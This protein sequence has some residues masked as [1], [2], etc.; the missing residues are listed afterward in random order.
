MDYLYNPHPSTRHTVFAK[1][2]MVATS[3]PLAA[4]AGIEIMRRGGNAIDAAIATAAALTVVEPTSNGIGGDAF[5][6]IW[7]NNKLHGLNAS[8]PAPQALTIDAVKAQGHDK[9]PVHGLTPITVPGVPA[10]WAELARKFGKLPLKESLEP[11]IRYAEEGYPLTPILGKYWSAAYKKYRTSFTT[12]EFDAWFT[13]FAPDGRAP[14]IGELW[15]SPDHAATLKSIGASNAESFYTGELADKI[16]AFMQQHGGYL[17][18]SDLANY[19]TE[20]VEPVSTNYRG[21]DVH[22]IPPNGQ[23][24]IA[25]MALN[26]LAEMNS[27]VPHDTQSL[28]EQIESMKLAFT[29]GQAFITEP[30]AMPIKPEHLLSKAYAQQRAA[31]IAATAT[32]PEPYELPKGG[33]VY[34]ATADG[35]GNMVSFIQSNYMGFGS[36]IV[37]P[38]T[39]IALQNRGADFS[40]DPNHPNALKPGK[41]TF[42]TIIPGFLTKNGQAVG[43]FGIMGGYM[44]PQG[45]FQVAINT[46][47]YKL[48]PQAAL[49]AP[50]WQWIKDN[51]V[52]VEPG[53]PNHLAQAL[54]RLGHQIQ[55]TLDT[56]SFGRG[57]IIWRNPETGVLSG[58]T[59]SRTDGAIAVW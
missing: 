42:H 34:L 2:G 11:A 43:P 54:V 7:V 53:F 58:G 40:L 29:D 46:I 13:T 36:G 32:H 30:S 35:E 12:E 26:I 14:E 39:G 28:H 48:N 6:L 44:Q 49:D 55:P 21:Y 59:E 22:E 51:L 3:Q 4:Q 50:R 9:M 15:K 16:D 38:G 8:G 37:I 52:H 41:R 23:G 57:Q 18:K 24:M 20:W 47:D 27:P 25:L 17:T 5:A 31:K 45:H 10:A 33:T 19:Q 56:G 1:N